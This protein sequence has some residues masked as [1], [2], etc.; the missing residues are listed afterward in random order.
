MSFSA[1]GSGAAGRRAVPPEDPF[2][3]AKTSAAA[4][5]GSGFGLAAL[6]CAATEIL[7]PAALVLGIIG[8]VVS[9]VGS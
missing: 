8:A 1:A 2:V 7:A 6:F 9:A 3:K 5:F 4:A